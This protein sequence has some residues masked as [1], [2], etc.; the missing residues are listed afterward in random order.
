MA[1]TV[2][3]LGNTSL[4]MALRITSRAHSERVVAEGEGVIVMLNYNQEEK[5][6][7]DDELRTAILEFESTGPA[8]NFSAH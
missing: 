1:T 4:V 7:L 6:P 3:R 8:E 5:V 2:T